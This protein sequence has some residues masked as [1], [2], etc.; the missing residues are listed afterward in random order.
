MTAERQLF[1]SPLQQQSD[2]MWR[3]RRH[4]HH[5]HEQLRPEVPQYNVISGTVY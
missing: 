5:F 3:R 1:N 2:W 4:R